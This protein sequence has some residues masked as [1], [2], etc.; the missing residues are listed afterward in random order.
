MLS[1]GTDVLYRSLLATNRI[2]IHRVEVWRQ[3]VRIDSYGDK[4]L[5]ITGGSVSAQL[6]SA[7]TRDL[8]ITA[9]EDL[10]PDDPQDPTELLTPWGNELRVFAGVAGTPGYIWPVFRGKITDVALSDAVTVT[11]NDRAADIGEDPFLVP[12]ASTAGA[13]TLDEFRRLILQTLPDAQFG[14][15]DDIWELVPS[16]IWEGS[17]SGACDDLARAAG[18]LWYCLAT[19]EFVMRRPPWS[20]AGSPVVTLTDGDGG[21]IQDADI[22]ISREGVA[23]VDTVI[24][25]RADVTLRP[26]HATVADSNPSSLTFV[27]GAF[28]RV[29]RLIRAQGVTTNAQAHSLATA[30]IRRTRALQQSWT[31]TMV[32]DASLELG[33]VATLRARRKRDGNVRTAVQ[34]VASFTL[35]LTGDG[36]MTVNWRGQEPPSPSVGS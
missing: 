16:L 31:T 23:N 9:H 1:G 28:G 27:D 26:A 14:T 5:P 24:G 15:S 32:P 30:W 2:P 11:A 8:A 17:R 13:R 35:P 20:V 29:G 6:S 33:D 4:G 21:V 12:R 18:A 25:E 19:G 34:V 7:V 22:R 36:P 3:G 10:F